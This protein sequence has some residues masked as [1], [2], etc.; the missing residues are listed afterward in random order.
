MNMY[1]EVDGWRN[2]IQFSAAHLIIGHKKCGRLHGHT[3]A[4]HTKIYGDRDID[5]FIIDFSTI[6][7]I[8]KEIANELDHKILIPE[9]NR[10]V[11]RTENEIKILF[12]NKTYI[13]PREDCALIP[14]K[15]STVENLAEHI[16]NQLIKKIILSKNIKKIEIGV[17]EGFGQGAKVEKTIG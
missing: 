16:L 2:N 15:S 7:T 1:L 12:D 9:K 13:F 14:F 4:V 8:L 6:K 3:Y 5:G 11:E 10:F 17:D